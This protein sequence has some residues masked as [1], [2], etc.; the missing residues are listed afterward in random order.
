MPTAR[1]THRKRLALEGAEPAAAT[2]HRT[3]IVGHSGVWSAELRTIELQ[4]DRRSMMQTER[5][6]ERS[7]SGG[8]AA[9]TAARGSGPRHG[10]SNSNPDR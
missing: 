5:R 3:R 1:V 9:G 2:G 6:D 8:N 7:S 10:R 4:R